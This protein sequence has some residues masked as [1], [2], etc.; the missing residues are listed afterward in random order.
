MPR[1]AADL[2]EALKKKGGLT[3]SQLAN[4]D[5][6]ITD[7]LVDRVYFWSTIRKLN[8]TYHPSRGVAEETTTDI[9][10]RHLIH[11][12]D[13][14]A[15]HAQLLLL[16]GIAKYLRQ[17]RTEDEKEHFER[18]LRKYINIY[19][20]DC[21][22]EVGTTNRYTVL[23]AEAA[24]YA[25]KPIRKGEAVKY[26]SGIQVAMT[27]AEERLLSSRTDFSIVLSSRRKRPSLF[28][29]PARFANHDCESNARLNTS[30][31]HGI[32]IV[33]R[34]DIGVG[35]EITVEYGEDYFGEGNGECLCASC[36]K[37][38]RNGWDPRGPL[39]R[40][41]ES[42]SEEEEEEVEAG[43]AARSKSSKGRPTPAGTA[44]VV[45]SRKRKRGEE[46]PSQSEPI[47][48]ALKGEKKTRGRPRKYP[49]PPGETMS[50]YMR[51][52]VAAEGRG[53]GA[54]RMAVLDSASRGGCGRESLHARA[55]RVDEDDDDDDDD[56]SGDDD[57]EEDSGE[58]EVV[59]EE[60]DGLRDP[61]LRGIVELLSSVGERSLRVKSEE[62]RTRLL[63]ERDGDELGDANK[64]G[65]TDAVETEVIVEHVGER[66][67]DL[68]P[69]D[70]Q[71][72]RAWWSREEDG[73]WPCG[74]QPLSRHEREREA[75]ELGG[76]VAGQRSKVS[77]QQYDGD[78]E[79]DSE[80]EAVEQ[81]AAELRADRATCEGLPAVGG[82][83]GKGGVSPEIAESVVEE[84]SPSGNADTADGAAA[85]YDAES[86]VAFAAQV[87]DNEDDNDR[88]GPGNATE[89]EREIGPPCD[90]PTAGSEPGTPLKD[91]RPRSP[92]CRCAEGDHVVTMARFKS[93]D[94]GP[95]TLL[96][97]FPGRG[98][99]ITGASGQLE[100]LVLCKSTGCRGV[101]VDVSEAS[102]DVSEASVV[103]G[104]ERDGDG[105]GDGD[106]VVEVDDMYE[107]VKTDAHEDRGE[108]AE[109]EN[110][111]VTIEMGEADIWSVP[112][113]PEPSTTTLR[114]VKRRK[115]SGHFAT[116]AGTPA[117]AST[118]SI[119]PPD[120][121]SDD[122][123]GEDGSSTGSS[124]MSMASSATSLGT[125]GG[126]LAKVEPAFHEEAFKAGDIALRICE[127]LTTALPSEE[128]DQKRDV[129]EDD[130]QET[131]VEEVVEKP[132]ATD[133]AAIARAARS[134][135]CR[136][137]A[138][139]AKQPA[140]KVQSPLLSKEAPPPPQRGRTSTRQSTSN[141][142]PEQSTPPIPSI[143]HTA[144]T[145]SPSTS[146]HPSRTGSETRG[147]ART[148]GDYHLCR[149]LLT[150]PYH[151]WVE[152]RNC[153]QHFVQADAYLTRIAC[154]RCE[155][156]SKLY[157]YYWPKTDREGKG[158][159]EERVRDHRTIHR[160]IEP[161]EE[162]GERKGRRG[163]GG[164]GWLGTEESGSARASG[165]R[166]QD[167]SE[168][169]RGS[170]GGRKLRGSP[171]GREGG[172][173][174]KVGERRGLRRT[175]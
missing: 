150:T 13:P 15:A 87:A 123:R 110:V 103:A 59:D 65:D 57:Q 3:L 119:S 62:Q 124:L 131:G 149:A 73:E 4:Y 14:S 113:S 91:A 174:K 76:D 169:V 167:S 45:S 5:D 130:E 90:E 78:E 79:S 51:L 18:H 48:S 134:A 139:R 47:D 10:R 30:G 93:M 155:R 49:L 37:G 82:G 127:M 164:A 42:E 111:G 56:E 170:A 61:M 23:T 25:R 77:Q 162:R 132:V 31:P 24:I 83:E 1:Q 86:D 104:G 172:V 141:T 101:G 92:S 9:L 69:C 158:D 145:R 28:L 153:D 109:V 112:S 144:P 137:R 173:G 80:P 159:R 54:R 108:V 135:K 95:G 38:G 71:A 161:G 100:E 146:S 125:L 163:L 138:G 99:A 72:P 22:F 94:R 52:Q 88:S 126:G 33:A 68:R 44:S 46:V 116:S 102:D 17:L 122:V 85:E 67:L 151:R 171:R 147:P 175:M 166:R 140:Q 129:S 157:G 133:R 53:S 107:V 154:P 26:L 16:P 148:P 81:L 12:R 156:H 96:G 20:P 89:H 117:Q 105:D 41:E 58:E 114:S 7:A 128:D 2:E 152:C 136:R 115:L 34:R 50:R 43:R 19:L 84:R 168:D 6:L 11:S 8:P 98:M 118:G 74:T 70:E 165:S 160:F 60:S 40:G 66:T 143:E 21:P 55:R 121:S 39:L 120:S 32:H 27:E 142:H 106:E 63:L 36:E 75:R 64:L 97:F 29:G 35:E